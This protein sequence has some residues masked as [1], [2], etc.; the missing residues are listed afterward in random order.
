MENV[1]LFLLLI[2]PFGLC[3]DYS[4]SLNYPFLLRNDYMGITSATGDIEN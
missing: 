2:S 3:L 1:L 4:F